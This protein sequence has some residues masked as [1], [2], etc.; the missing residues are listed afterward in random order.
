MSL[1]ALDISDLLGMSDWDAVLHMS[2]NVAVLRIYIYMY[3]CDWVAVLHIS[4]RRWDGSDYVAG[5][6]R[7]CRYAAHTRR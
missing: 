7:Q 3:I 5:C 1:V 2:D 4:D 6:K